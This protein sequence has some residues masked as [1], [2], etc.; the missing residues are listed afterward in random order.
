M[1]RNNNDNKINSILGPEVE[2][3]GDTIKVSK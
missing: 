2:I 3:N 1:L